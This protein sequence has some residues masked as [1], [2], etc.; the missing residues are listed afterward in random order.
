MRVDYDGISDSTYYFE[1]LARLT[2]LRE[3]SMQPHQ[4]VQVR[5]VGDD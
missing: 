2:R 1:S 5:F 3:V 4:D